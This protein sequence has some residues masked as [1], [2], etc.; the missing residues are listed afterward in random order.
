ML[1]LPAMFSAH[2][3]RTGGDQALAFGFWTFVGKATL[4]V[5]AGLVLPALAWAGFD[6]SAPR[7]P[8]ALGALSVLYALMPCGLKAGAL[9]LLLSV[10]RESETRAYAIQ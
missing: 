1:L 10:F 3:A 4:A 5:S 9:A 8:A 6:P 7:D 2:Q